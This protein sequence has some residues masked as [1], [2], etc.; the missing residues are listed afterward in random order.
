MTLRLGSGNLFEFL[1]AWLSPPVV[2]ATLG[3]SFRVTKVD[4]FVR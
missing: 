3:I 1:K 2:F 4:E